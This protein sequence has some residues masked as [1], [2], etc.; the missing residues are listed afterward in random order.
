M[1]ICGMISILLG[2]IGSGAKENIRELYGCAGMFNIG[3][4][5]IL[6]SYMSTNDIQAGIIF[7]LIYLLSMFGIYSCFYGIRSHGEYI[8]QIEYLSGMNE[9][10]PYIS[11]AFLLFSA[12]LLGIPPLLGLLGNLALLKSL[13]AHNSFIIVCFTFLM[14]F[15]LIVNILYNII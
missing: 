13:L 10:K 2:A 11:A 1:L 4:V 12:S 7:F 15:F 6:F 14:M 5:L 3:I 8:T 9:V